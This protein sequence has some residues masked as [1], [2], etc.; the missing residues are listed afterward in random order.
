MGAV[1]DFM[2]EIL[3]V[4]NKDFAYMTRP[5][6]DDGKDIKLP[7][8]ENILSMQSIILDSDDKYTTFLKDQSLKNG[9]GSVALQMAQLASGNIQGLIFKPRES[10]D[11]SNICDIAA[12]YHI[13]KKSGIIV[14]DYDL[15][16]FD[17]KKPGKGLVAGT[18]SFMDLLKHS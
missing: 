5:N 2:R 7:R 11:M 10:D 1:Y 15:N 4:S 3:Y 14:K 13:M 16:E 12:G 6:W 17:Y 9:S 18:K 8:V